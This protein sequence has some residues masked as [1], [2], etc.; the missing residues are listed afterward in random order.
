MIDKNIL[1]SGAKRLL[2]L[3]GISLAA[4]W[5]V[6]EVAFGLQKEKHDRPP[7]HVNL[8][9]P[10]G[11]FERVE[12]G[13]PAPSIPEEMIFVLGDTLVVKNEDS[14]D[15]QLGPVWVPAGS[16][17]SLVLEQPGKYAYSCSFQPNRYLGLDVRK[18][19]T[20][21]TRATALGLATPALAFFLF[22]YSL[23]LRPIQP[24]AVSDQHSDPMTEDAPPDGD[25]LVS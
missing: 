20:W 2:V 4:V 16:Q 18:A 25:G 10:A 12:A 3:F 22:V 8:V 17:A 7:Q 19:T 23:V 1:R 21:V 13:Q 15:H 11:T 6:S 9:I 24:K 5:L 14:V